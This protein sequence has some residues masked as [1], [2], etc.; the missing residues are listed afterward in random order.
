MTLIPLP[1]CPMCKMNMVATTTCGKSQQ[2]FQCQCGHLETY[3]DGE[4]VYECQHCGQAETCHF[5]LMILD[6]FPKHELP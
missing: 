4:W 3:R 1:S 2:T 5:R 6:T